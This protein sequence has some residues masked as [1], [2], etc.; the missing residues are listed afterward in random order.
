M[1][2]YNMLLDLFLLSLWFYPQ[3]ECSKEDC[4][5]SYCKHVSA[6]SARGGQVVGLLVLDH[7][8]IYVVRRETCFRDQD[9]GSG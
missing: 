3:K 2:A 6:A 8:L 5:A 1:D 7:I 4:Y 9:R